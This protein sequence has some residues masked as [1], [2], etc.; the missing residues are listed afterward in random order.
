MGSQ[1]LRYHLKSIPFFSKHNSPIPQGPWHLFP[2][3]YAF[4][5]ISKSFFLFFYPTH[6]FSIVLLCV[7]TL[8]RKFLAV[9]SLYAVLPESSLS[10]AR[11]RP[12]FI[13]VNLGKCSFFVRISSGYIPLRSP[14]LP[15]RMLSHTLTSVNFQPG[16]KFAPSHS[17]GIW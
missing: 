7:S 9:F 11:F 4:S 3:S 5:L 8:R 16:A 6:S 12:P 17:R 10:Q 15:T 2:Y 1:H 14:A 13:S